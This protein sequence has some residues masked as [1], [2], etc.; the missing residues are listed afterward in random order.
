MTSKAHCIL[1]VMNYS[2]AVLRIELDLESLE[3]ILALYSYRVWLDNEC[4][5]Q[6]RA[7]VRQLLR[8][9]LHLSVT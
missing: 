5:N 4:P 6:R 9:E 3:S 7:L 2:K 8:F 1:W